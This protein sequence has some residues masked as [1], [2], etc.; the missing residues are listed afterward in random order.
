MK[1]RFLGIVLLVLVTCSC[2]GRLGT[3]WEGR[4]QINNLCENVR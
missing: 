2:T 4:D 1:I 3:C